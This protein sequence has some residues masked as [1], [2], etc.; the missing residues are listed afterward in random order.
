MPTNTAPYTNTL[1]PRV[2]I[3]TVD[4]EDTLYTFD[5]FQEDNDIGI[6][7]I[8]MENAVG[9]TGTFSMQIHDH[10]NELSKDN[11]H[12]IKAYF[13]L[14]KTDT[15]FQHF[16]I[17]FGDVFR[18]ER[19][20]T[21]AQLYT[22][23]GFG[24]KIWAYQ[25]FIHR[26]ETYKRTESDAKV[27]NQVDNAL[28]KRLWRPQKTFDRSIQDITGWSRDGI[29]NKVNTVNTVVNKPFT[30]FGDFLD[31][32]CD[33]TGA[34]WFIDYSTGEEILTL[35]YNPDLQTNVT[36]KSL[37]LA[38]RNT[39]DGSK[40]AY[41]KNTFG[42]ED[43][44]TTESGTET[45]LITVSVQ[46]NVNVFEIEPTV[47]KTSLTNRA[48]AQQVVID[49]DTRRIEEIELSL[50]KKGDPQSN[51]NR[52]NGDIVL[53]NGSNKPQG[54]VL[55]E[56]NIDLGS[57]KHNPEKFRIQV[58]ISEKDLD[59]AQS[60][61]WIRLFQRSNGE[62]V[63]GNPDGNSDP[64]TS[65]EH[66]VYWHHNNVLN[67]TQPY[68]SATVSEGDFDK[69][70]TY[71]WNSTNQGPMYRLS[72]YSNIR[73]LFART[74][75]QAA[76]RIRLREQLIDTSFLNDPNDIMRYVSLSL[77]Q[78]SKG[79]RV[80]SNIIST[81]PNDFLFR[82]YQWVNFSDGLSD[83]SDT[84]QVQRARYVIGT[85]TNDPQIGTLFADLTLSGLYNTLVGSCTCI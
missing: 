28:T 46:D 58:D 21:N 64:N 65:T 2:T 34:V 77:S 14:G 42:L 69:K 29:S 6:S 74:N 15:S 45:R 3:K 73:R 39:D 57:I 40:I 31:E 36:L 18:I 20:Q 44:A 76:K 54:N 35:S 68:Y 16:L 70:D 66:E 13:E 9:E 71:N 33:I 5:G 43:N 30:Y 55:D 67:T 53:D 75:S 85:N 47:G 38:N 27:Y 63:D 81:I 78:S 49:N 8:E 23:N 82:P 59:V 17:G 10:N 50:S 25:L 41:F 32:L 4:G 7:S 62:D 26:R 51:K 11:L 61:I 48:I 37:E 22:I 83:I 80:V 79:R 72:I 84:L 56:F 1:R 12:N 24:T 19:P 60:K 52:V